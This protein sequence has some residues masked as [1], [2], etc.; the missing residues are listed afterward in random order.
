MDLKSGKT[1]RVQFVAY[2]NSVR[3]SNV[4]VS[5]SD[6][7]Q[8]HYQDQP[9]T[10][11]PTAY[12]FQFTMPENNPNTYISFGIGDESPAV[13]FE[14][15]SIT[16][17]DCHPCLYNHKILDQ[18]IMDGEYQVE[19]LIETNS[20]ALPNANIVFKADQIDLTSG[21]E[22]P[23]GVLFEALNDPCSH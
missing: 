14:D 1:Y 16:S 2:A 12:S 8:Y 9:L 18:T 15:V 23:A 20:T 21:F 5:R 7:S 6:G 13:Y 4:I 19:H 10:T 17:I 22:V 3:G 11:S